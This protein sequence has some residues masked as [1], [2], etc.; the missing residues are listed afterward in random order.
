MQNKPKEVH[1]LN[2]APIHL[3]PLDVIFKTCEV[4]NYFRMKI[5]K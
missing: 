5:I 1:G 4:S 2:L 3:A